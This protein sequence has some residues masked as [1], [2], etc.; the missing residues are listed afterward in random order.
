VPSS[1]TEAELRDRTPD[2]SL[3]IKGPSVVQ[4]NVV[5]TGSVADAHGPNAHII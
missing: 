5:G 1:G 2:G 3:G 4:N